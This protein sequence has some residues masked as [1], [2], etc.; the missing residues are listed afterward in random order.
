MMHEYCILE[1]LENKT[2]PQN[3]LNVWLCSVQYQQKIQGSRKQHVEDILNHFCFILTREYCKY[4]LVMRPNWDS[5]S[6]INIFCF[7]L[8]IIYCEI[9]IWRLNFAF[10]CSHYISN[11]GNLYT[12]A[13][14][15]LS[16]SLSFQSFFYFLPCDFDIFSFSWL[17]K[18]KSTQEDHYHL[19]GTN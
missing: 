14:N 11:K 7:V 4:P 16:F 19:I 8:I 12:T 2:H 13:K 6:V 15:L 3:S 18:T 17:C 1:L 9:N 10:G 5:K